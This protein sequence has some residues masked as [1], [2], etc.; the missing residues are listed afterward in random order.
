M[1][2][3][4]RDLDIFENHYIHG[5]LNT[6]QLAAIHCHSDVHVNKIRGR[7]RQ[8][9]EHGYIKILPSP[10]DE[11]NVSVMTQQA[12][13]ELA[14][15]RHYPPRRISIPR[16]SKQYR[17]HDLSLSDFTVTF[18]LFVR[19]LE[20]AEIIDELQLI[21][22]SPRFDVRSHRGWPVSFS[23]EGLRHD[24]WLKPDRFLGIEFENRA[25]NQNVR[26]YAIEL[27]RGTMPIKSASM[28]KASIQ[29]KFLA[30]QMTYDE[31]LLK[32]HFAIPHAYVLFICHSDRR[33]NHM[34]EAAQELI[35]S[36]S[37]ARSMLLATQTKRP[38]VGEFTDL[39]NVEWFNGL[40]KNVSL[41]L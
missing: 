3:T 4:D 25:A 33:R 21:H 1:D 31:K 18:D 5:L 14:S 22:R 27:D 11:P 38:S 41:P 2:I 29:R 32:E 30:Y 36:E 12:M 40:G 9:R 24:H 7:M 35:S 13:N 23:H 15:K 8:L 34:I 19:S 26:Y 6:E 17:K 28:D 10:I 37:A 39:T 16:S 20:G